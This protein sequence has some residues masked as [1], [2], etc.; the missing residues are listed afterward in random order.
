MRPPAGGA[1][2]DAM[3]TA[4]DAPADSL[5]P[6]ERKMIAAIREHGW[7]GTHVAGEDGPSFTYSTGFCVNAGHPEVIFCGLPMD[8][9]HDL[10]W[11]VFEAVRGGRV[12]PIG[13]PIH[14][15]FRDQPAFAFPVARRY[16]P[17][18][19][20]GARWFYGGDDFE[21]LQIVWNDPAGRFPWEA[22]FDRR[23]EFDQPD[24]TEHGWRV[25]LP[26]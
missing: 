9:A 3:R 13:S 15:L 21:C 26:Q 2:F 12:F 23:F 1:S 14:E 22:G 24:L 17:E 25:A 6:Y 16:Y 4:L 8:L 20:C 19:L 5:N 11:D 10:L 7:W 18:Y